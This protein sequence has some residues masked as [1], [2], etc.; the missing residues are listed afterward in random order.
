MVYCIGLRVIVLAQ[1]F[2][3]CGME[4]RLENGTCHGDRD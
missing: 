1:V 4:S 2:G 3:F